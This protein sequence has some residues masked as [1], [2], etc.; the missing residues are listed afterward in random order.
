MSGDVKEFDRVNTD[1]SVVKRVNGK[2]GVKE[3]GRIFVQGEWRGVE[4]IFG[5]Y[6]SEE[7]AES[8]MHKRIK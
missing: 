6:L 8:E 5:Q 7:E 2:F 1:V 4:S 3:I